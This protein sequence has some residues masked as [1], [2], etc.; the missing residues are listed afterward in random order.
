MKFC[1]GPYLRYPL[2]S[3]FFF[4]FLGSGL[5]VPLNAQ[6]DPPVTP[7]FPNVTQTAG[8]IL[9]GLNEPNQGRTAI[10][11]YHNGILF[12]LPELPSSQ[13]G[14]DFQV[15]TW[16]ISD[17]TLP[18]VTSS[19]GISPMPINAHGYFKSGDY[20]VVG[21]NWP[22]E[23]PWSF[24]ADGVGAVERT[25]FPGL[26]CAGGR[27][28][29]SQPWLVGQ[30]YWSYGEVSGDAFIELNGNRFSQWDH[31][32]LT[33]VVGHPFLVGDLLIFASDQS[34]TGLATYDVSDPSNPVLLDV[35]TT[36]GPGGYWPELWGGDGKLYAVFPYR[37]NGNGIRVADLTDPSDLKFLADTPLPGD[38]AMYMQF[39]DE[40]AFTGGHKVD[41][42]T[43]ESVL[44]LDGANTTRP[45][46][47]GLGIDTSQFALP[48]G[49]LLVTGG[50][51][52]LQGMAIWAHQAAPDT[53]GPSVGFHI[54]QAGRTNYP[55]GAP[56]SLLIHETLETT[57]IINGA[58]F[59]VQPLGGSPI[60]GRTV[61]SFNDILTF[62]PDQPLMPNTTY[63]VL[64]PAGGIKD[65][66]GNG[67]VGYG[68]TFSTGST[69][70]GNVA[71]VVESFSASVYPAAP[72]QTVTLSAS[73]SDPDGGAVEY[74]FDFGDGS[75][76]TSWSSGATA[77][78]G[79]GERGHYQA[80]VQVRDAAGAIAT[81]THTV[82]V[83]TAAAG[84]QPTHS[85]AVFCDDAQ[86][87]VWTV[88]PDN[89][90][91]SAVDADTQAK[92]LEVPVC[93]D[94]RSVGRSA[95]GQIWVTCFD[96]DRIRVL[97]AAGGFVADIQEDYGSAPMGLA[98]S[99][100][101]ATAYVTLQGSG[102]LV[103]YDATSRQSTGRL[104]LGPRPRA[105]AVSGDGARV[106]VTRLLSPRDHGEVWE[107]NAPSLTL[108]RTLRLPK[109]GGDSNRDSTAAGRGAANYL[110]GIA[111]SPDGQSAFVTA[112]KPNQEKGLLF[113]DDLDQDN[114]VRNI[115]VRVDLTTG[116]V[117]N[118]VD[119]DNSD[120]ASAVAFS[121][122]G[123]YLFV[124]LQGNDEVVVLDALRLEETV[125]LGSLVT[126]LGAGSAP[127]GV[128]T[129]ATSQR[130]FVKNFTGRSL[131]SLDTLELF[132]SGNKNVGSTEIAAVAAEALPPQVLT[133]KQIFYHGGDPRMSGEGYLSCASCHLD[134]GHDGRTW[135]FTG[136]GEGLRNT[137]SLRGRGGMAHGNVHWTANFDEI[138]D[139]END[140]RGAFGGDGFLS[141][142]DF[143]ATS[144]P[145]GPPKA[146]LD[147]D[148]DALAA[149]VTSLGSESVP[150]SPHRAPDGALTPQ[151]EAGRTVFESLNCT[152][153]HSGTAFTDST[154]GVATLH[155]VGTIRTT[156]GQRIGGPL[157]GLD[158]PTLAGLWN[159]APYFHD[160]S[161]GTLFEV[162]Q[163]AG[164]VVYP[165][166]TGS[167]SGGA[168]ITDQ[169]VELNNDDT[170]H[171]RA[172]VGLNNTGARVTLN[173]VDGGN[174]GLG[175]VEV[176]YSV[177]NV[178]DLD[179]TVNGA[180]QT[181]QMEDVG[182]DPR[183]RH[184]NWRSLRL[185]DISLNA[186]A[187]NTIE[188]SSAEAFPNVSLDEVVVTTIDDRLAAQPHRQVMLLS[189]GDREAL[190]AFLQQ[191]DGQSL[192]DPDAAIFS[193]GFESG[194]TAAWTL[195]VP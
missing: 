8:A 31:L 184:T 169:Y 103:S 160:G 136:R 98:F 43:F 77:G 135:D 171:G 57:T 68:F 118:G 168:Q 170:V 53:R 52:S 100:D 188:V 13:P 150:K 179:I 41:M 74:R 97:D 60:T 20:L 37:S 23:A 42:R 187:S 125:G 91:L 148:L 24:R 133:G 131:T 14:S 155:D 47:G 51:G 139:F 111:L 96:D 81:A 107:V 86:R 159:T 164:G 178:Q 36:G 147:A 80:L 185:E 90:S 195:T 62:T 166:E 15:R 56:I 84:P 16:D 116:L 29:L 21:S 32:G 26:V 149:Y 5:P 85:T 117:T 75:P 167:V 137:T 182:N 19:L 92:E 67:I 89:D 141:E 146:G 162:F 177:W 54:P 95:Q 18:V 39:Q 156:S 28:C 34:R 44:F 144:D 130:T 165:A 151:G 46:D 82:T 83:T 2:I 120:S 190:I 11:A 76:R 35:L 152:Q 180:T 124:A 175:A 10:I 193:D 63:E 192:G 123:D 126:R 72:G 127:Q 145:L 154:L 65:A 119:L 9:S 143:G 122:L 142:A 105:L 87:R 71:P 132:R 110:V 157:D 186:G 106:L 109:F 38:A 163:E 191:L 6:A 158:T 88:N 7:G 73:G 48:L 17:P 112:N 3:S 55:V 33:G 12:T 121:P 59:I 101:G 138:Q 79:Y 173:G 102:E 30:T 174:G 69:V 1:R 94:P 66:A 129:D 22:P 113:G 128:C 58:T 161:A 181:V 114:T 176:R 45:N 153:C 194:D 172:Y 78:H 49:N 4:L 99:P 189:E 27:G 25:E 70:G 93:A 61:F 104:F 183:W 50:V 140:I 134:G 115:L 64:L 108:N 40:Y